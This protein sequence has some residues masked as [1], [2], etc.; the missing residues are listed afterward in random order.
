MFGL[1]FS[2]KYLFFLRSAQP[3]EPVPP[4][5][6]RYWLET[7]R[8]PLELLAAE[9]DDAKGPAI[10]FCHGGMGGAWVWT[11]YMTYLKS[12]GVR[13]YAISLR[14]HGDSWCPHFLRMVYGTTR[15]DLESDLVT[16]VNWVEEHTGGDVVLAGHS[17][18]GGLSQAVLAAGKVKARGLALL[19]AVPAFGSMGVYLNWARLD[20][21][22]SLRMLFHLWHPNSPLSHPSLTQAA[23]FGSSFPAARV[24]AFQHRTSRFE[25]FWWPLSMMR[26]FA[27]AAQI[28]AGV[29]SRKVLVMAGDQDA[30]MTPDVTR[31]T[32]AFYRAESETVEMELVEGAGHHLQNDVQWEDG[33]RRLLTWY[34]AL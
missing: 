29:S 32:A 9:P 20:P 10:V 16:A 12:Q 1:T 14:G 22:F 27:K 18:G 2:Y 4:G 23:F 33:A 5:L 26:P 11:E 17:S 8:G 21:W 3:A 25:S 19:G 15:A 28:L 34:R 13:C 24:P 7:P 6:H 31:T 30:L